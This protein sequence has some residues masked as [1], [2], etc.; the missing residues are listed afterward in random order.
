MN[1]STASID[2][3]MTQTYHQFEIGFF[4]YLGYRMVSCASNISS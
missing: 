4:K 2:F 3:Y 1:R